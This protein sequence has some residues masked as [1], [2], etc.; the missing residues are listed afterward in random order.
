MQ[1][2]E[3]ERAGEKSTIQLQKI[4]MRI[5]TVA[6]SDFKRLP[7]SYQLRHSQHFILFFGRFEKTL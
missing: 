5:I 2:N 3:R 1:A 4:I 6:C 7:L